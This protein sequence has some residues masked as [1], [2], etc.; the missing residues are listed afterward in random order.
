MNDPTSMSPGSV[1]PR[2]PWLL[3]HDL[4]ASTT[5]AKISALRSLGVPYPAGYESKAADDL[6]SQASQIAADLTRA[7]APIDPGKEII[8]LIA[9]L[10]RL[11]IDIKAAPQGARP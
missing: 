8:A 2:Y 5:A 6:Q 11:G 10:Q 3:E 4:D 7:G 1:M 9:Y